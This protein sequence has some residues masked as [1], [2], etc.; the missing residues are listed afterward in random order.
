MH[1]ASIG[2][3]NTLASVYCSR[4]LWTHEVLYCDTVPKCQNTEV[5]E[6]SQRHPLLCSILLKHVSVAVNMHSN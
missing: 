4:F 2:T 5:R 1:L 6:V 3:S